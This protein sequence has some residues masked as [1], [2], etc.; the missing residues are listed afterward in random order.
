MIYDYECQRCLK[1]QEVF[2][3]A[4]ERPEVLCACGG[5]CLKLIAT[6]AM[7]CG[8]NGRA[9]MYN[10]VDFNTTGKPVV[11]NSKTQWR[12]HLKRTGLND[13]VKNDPYT[14]SELEQKVRDRANK[15]IEHRREIKKAVTEVYKKRKT[16][17]FKKRVKEALTNR[18]G[19]K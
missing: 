9:D 13:D 7:F 15:K 1:T 16:P 12:E 5:K 18:E 17:E 6:G 11:I 3:S 19:G 4:M 2:H 10:F 8:V 14:K